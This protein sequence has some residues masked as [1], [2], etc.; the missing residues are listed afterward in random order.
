MRT[1][2]A[3]KPIADE[4]DD[5]ADAHF[6]S[7]KLRL[8]VDDGLGDNAA[9]GLTLEESSLYPNPSFA[10]TSGTGFPFE[11]RSL[12]NREIAAGWWQ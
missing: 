8:D 2:L 6:T 10:R 4:V 11:K 1:N 5:N 12:V 9:F 3:V 7:A